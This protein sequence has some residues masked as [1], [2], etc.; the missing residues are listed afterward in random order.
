MVGLRRPANHGPPGRRWHTAGSSAWRCIHRA[1]A[2]RTERLYRS[3]VRGAGPDLRALHYLPAAG[4]GR[5]D[6]APFAGARADMT[7]LA[8]E[9]PAGRGLVCENLSVNFGR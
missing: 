8:R 7:E 9:A 2:G 4:L 1:A 6:R 5:A 3:L